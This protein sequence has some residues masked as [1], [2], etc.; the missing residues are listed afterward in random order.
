MACAC[1]NKTANNAQATKVK[2]VVKSKSVTPVAG[3]PSN[4][5]HR[6]TKRVIYRRSV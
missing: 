3:T 1:K 6:V 4:T 2:Q 5:G